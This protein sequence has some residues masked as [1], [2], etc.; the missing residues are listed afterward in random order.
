M[1]WGA[2]ALRGEGGLG[3]LPQNLKVILL[4]SL[5][6]VCNLGVMPKP[7]AS[8][9]YA[10]LHTTIPEE[11]LNPYKEFARALDIPMS[12]ILTAVLEPAAPYIRELAQVASEL[13]VSGGGITP[14]VSA[15]VMSILARGLAEGHN[16]FVE[17]LRRLEGAKHVQKTE[18]E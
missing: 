2:H 8:R 9:P 17:E 3:A 14:E 10:R 18:M 1:V 16:L 13:R 5:L 12:V 7:R 11:V 4:T 15:R 6:A